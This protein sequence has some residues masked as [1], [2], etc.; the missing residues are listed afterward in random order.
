MTLPGA[1]RLRCGHLVEDV[2]AQVADGRGAERDAHQQTCPHCQAA[3]AEYQRLWAPMVEIAATRVTA[4][5]SIIDNALQRIRGVVEHTDY[6]VLTSTHGIT[7]ISARVVVSLARET[8]QTV[9][10]VR[11]ALSKNLTDPPT[12]QPDQYGSDVTAGVVGRSTA[13]EIILAADYGQDLVA[14]GEQVRRVVAAR[15][16][17]L[18]DL[19]PVAITVIV[20]DV[21]T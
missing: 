16:H 19:Q 2:L 20:D 17:A 13:I 6:G 9:P 4:P 3:L 1:D 12:G 7:R 10:G 15:V 5:D 21:L 14:L 18:T 11:V 8:A